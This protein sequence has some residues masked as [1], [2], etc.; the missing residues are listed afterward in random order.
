VIEPTNE[1]YFAFL[2]S[3]GKGMPYLAQTKFQ[4]DVSIL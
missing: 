1:L 2:L 3:E 4:N